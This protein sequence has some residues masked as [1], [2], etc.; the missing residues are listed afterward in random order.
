MLSGFGSCAPAHGAFGFLVPNSKVLGM[1]M[2]WGFGV[3]CKDS[4]VA[5]RYVEDLG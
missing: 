3:C 2:F 1:L 4:L 5:S